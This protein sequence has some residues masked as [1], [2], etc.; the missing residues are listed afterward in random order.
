[1]LDKIL[2]APYYL[3]LKLR[4]FLFDHGIRRV[5][6]ADV[7]T[8]CIGNITAGGT[9][10]TPHT[11]MVLRTLLRSDEWAYSNLAVLSRG[12]RR[13]SSGFQVVTRD[14]DAEDFGDEPLQI[15][16]KFPGVTVAVD[17][18]RVE[19]CDFLCHPEK[20][21]TEKKARKC[22]VKEIEPADLI[23]LDDAFQFRAL[24]ATLN[25]LLVDYNRP[26]QKD[27]LLPFGR[28]RDLPERLGEA[29]ILI[30][31]KCPAYLQD[32]ERMQWAEELR[33]KEYDLAT[34]KGK[35]RKGREKLLL[36]SAIRYDGMLPVFPEEADRRYA[37]A[38]KLV[39]FT[40]IA[41]DTPLRRYLSD[42]YRIVKH[43]SF[44]DH[45][46]YTAADIRKVARAT[47]EHPTAVVTT[48][49][50]DSQ[51]IER[52]SC[53]PADLRAKLFQVPIQV[54]FLTEEEQTLFE[55][56]LFGAIRRA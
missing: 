52:L 51:R 18:N 49:E 35:D 54:G 9:G 14:G 46:K 17:R 27:S 47:A 13:K 43:F 25:I 37:Y 23:V 38:Q 10:K 44:A 12:Y 36:F 33:L 53:I 11:E 5:H 29:D 19:G 21:K 42:K 41:K 4:H 32:E 56:A 22:R 16:K 20:L 15:K 8:L 3:T 26:V 55:Q 7:P 50:K 45:H 30:V 40:G 28:L 24:K 1:M 48:T 34:C 2:L 39:L 31:T 6:Q